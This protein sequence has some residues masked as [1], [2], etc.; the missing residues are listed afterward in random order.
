MSTLSRKREAGENDGD[1][2]REIGGRMTEK[3]RE[4]DALE[5]DSNSVQVYT[6]DIR[7]R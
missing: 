5:T 2:N 1:R 3:E 6:N 4:R 7:F